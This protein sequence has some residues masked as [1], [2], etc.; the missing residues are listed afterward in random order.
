MTDLERDVLR[1]WD[2]VVPPEDIA[3][4]LM[5]TEETV[6]DIIECEA[7]YIEQEEICQSS[8]RS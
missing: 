2:R 7:N 1:L 8:D 3:K 4:Y 6:Q 5:V